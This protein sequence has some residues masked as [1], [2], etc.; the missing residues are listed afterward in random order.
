MSG[1]TRQEQA[2]FIYDNL[3]L[4]TQPIAVKFL[5]STQFP[6]KTRRPS[7]VFG[8]TS[9]NLSGRHHGQSIWLARRSG[10]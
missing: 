3:R 8:K 4:R 6:E 5:E 7:E 2:N 10:T 9:D 1:S